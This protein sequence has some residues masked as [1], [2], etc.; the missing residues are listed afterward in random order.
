MASGMWVLAFHLADAQLWK[1]VPV[2]SRPVGLGILHATLVV[3]L[4]TA[5]HVVAVLDAP[6][7]VQRSQQLALRVKA[8]RRVHTVLLP[9]IRGRE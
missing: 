4:Q 1:F 7:L 6:L 3:V 8:V 5:W 9:V 2:C